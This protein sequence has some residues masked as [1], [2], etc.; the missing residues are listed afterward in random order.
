MRYIYVHHRKVRLPGNQ[1]CLVCAKNVEQQK[2]LVWY[3]RLWDLQSGMSKCP[4]RYHVVDFAQSISDMHIHDDETV[5]AVVWWYGLKM[6]HQVQVHLSIHAGG[7]LT[8]W[9]NVDPVVP[10]LDV[11]K[12]CAVH[13]Q[14][15]KFGHKWKTHPQMLLLPN[16]IGRSGWA[17]KTKFL[18]RHELVEWGVQHDLWVSTTSWVHQCPR[19]NQ[20]LCRL[21]LSCN[22][23]RYV[24]CDCEAGWLGH[25]AEFLQQSDLLLEIQKA[26]QR[27]EKHG[28]HDQF[29]TIDFLAGVFSGSF[30]RHRS[31][32]ETSIWLTDLQ[33]SASVQTG[34]FQKIANNIY[35]MEMPILGLIIPKK[36]AAVCNGITIVLYEMEGCNMAPKIK[37][38]FTPFSKM[39]RV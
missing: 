8:M 18:C 15:T 10:V 30:S 27:H 19:P 13:G 2:L 6:R 34:T 22:Q 36:N 14:Y 17:P 23:N 24:S 12:L 4:L 39:G 9:S 5:A 7:H 28:A 16:G 32:K 26:Q 38:F 3:H 31:L 21:G 20:L 1:W 35:I 37:G 33:I 25:F 11:G 29:P